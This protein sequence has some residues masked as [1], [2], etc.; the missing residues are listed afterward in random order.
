MGFTITVLK[1]GHEGNHRTA[2]VDFTGDSSYPTGGEVLA[3]A[4]LVKLMPELRFDTAVAADA[5]KLEAL[6]SELD[7][8]GRQLVLDRANCKL[9]VFDGGVEIANATNLSAVTIRALIKYDWYK[10][11]AS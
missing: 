7:T 10:D 9:M 5:A 11:S 1:R 4:D 8:T 6:V 3:V 2:L